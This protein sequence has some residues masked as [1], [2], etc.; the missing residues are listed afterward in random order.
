MQGSERCD[1]YVTEKTESPETWEVQFQF[2]LLM[3]TVTANSL[4]F[5]QQ[6]LAFVD[7]TR[8]NPEFRDTPL[9]GERYRT[10][11]EKSID[12][13]NCFTATPFVFAKNGEYDSSYVLRI[14][15]MTNLRMLLEIQDALLDAFMGSLRDVMDGCL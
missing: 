14:G 1:I 4:S 10:M 6:I 7:E 9:G 8:N 12:L 5:A 2:R 11:S 3:V 15:S 13:S